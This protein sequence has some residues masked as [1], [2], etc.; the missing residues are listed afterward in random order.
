MRFMIAL[1]ALVMLT[2]CLDAAPPM[3][4][5]YNGRLVKL[6]HHNY[7]LGDN[8]RG[9]PLY[10]KAVEVCGSDATYQGMRNLGPNQG[11]HAFLCVG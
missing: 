3:V 10:T 9:S 6:A 2:A 4:T 7:P 11:E 1:P 8:Y 5:D